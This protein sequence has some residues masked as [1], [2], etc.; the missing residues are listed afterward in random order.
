MTSRHC[1]KW[2]NVPCGCRCTNSFHARPSLSP[3]KARTAGTADA[4]ATE[5]AA[6]MGLPLKRPQGKSSFHTVAGSSRSSPA[7]KTQTAHDRALGGH[8]YDADRHW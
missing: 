3:A 5:T 6:F 1:D 2:K 7:V 4:A 8:G